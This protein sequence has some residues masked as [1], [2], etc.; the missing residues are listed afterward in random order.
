MD[1]FLVPY[2]RVLRYRCVKQ[3]QLIAGNLRGA[4]QNA[5]DPRESDTEVLW[6]PHPFSLHISYSYVKNVVGILLGLANIVKKKQY[7]TPFP[8]PLSSV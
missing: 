3:A 6:A 1:L 5:A 8:H 4:T 7:I 2:S